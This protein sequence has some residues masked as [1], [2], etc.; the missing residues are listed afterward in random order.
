MTTVSSEYLG[1]C[2]PASFGLIWA[3]GFSRELEFAKET[4][5]VTL[6]FLVFQWRITVVKK[7][8][9]SG[10]TVLFTGKDRNS[11]SGLLLRNAVRNH[12]KIVGGEVLNGMWTLRLTRRSLMAGDYTSRGFQAVTVSKRPRVLL[13]SPVS[14]ELWKAA[15]AGGEFDYNMILNDCA[16]RL[17]ILTD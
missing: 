2:F 5:S 6:G 3:G 11:L 16:R 13:E 10:P 12:G 4:V 15:W 9:G 1:S 8:E 7:L 14:K 17:G